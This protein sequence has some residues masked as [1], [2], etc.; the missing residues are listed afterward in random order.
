MKKNLSKHSKLLRVIVLVAVIPVLLYVLNIRT[1]FFEKA[2]QS[3]IGQKA[4]IS[5]DINNL[6]PLNPT[7]VYLSQGG[8]ERKG[9][10]APVLSKIQTL[11]PK[12]IRVDHIFDFYEPVKKDASGN[13]SFDWTL[14]DSEINDILETGAKPFLSLSYMPSAISRGSEIDIPASWQDWQF[15]IQKTIEHISGRGGLAISDVYYEVWNE[16]DLFGGFKLSGDK[17]YLTLYYYASL[18][19]Q[20][21]SNT[22]PFKF[23]GPATTHLR[24]DWFDRLYSLLK[25]SS[26]RLDFYSWHLYSKQ[27][28]NYAKDFTNV[29]DYLL[30]FGDPANI[31]FIITESG[32]DSEVNKDY[33]SIF[34]AIHTLALYTST[35]P[36]EDKIFLF[37][38][39]DGPGE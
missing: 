19:A 23:G 30:S 16:P 10:L 21:A 34:S 18:G 20:S 13:L 38:I 31:E 22:L 27:I 39:K 9:S 6:Y 32:I 25:R 26:L 29:K 2:S 8:E 33:D 11:K 1:N 35:F 37:E 7:W 12:Y 24:R 14:L 17:N 5:V 36:R 15:T 4:N 28:V 3:L